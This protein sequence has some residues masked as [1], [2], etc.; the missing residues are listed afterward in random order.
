MD[1]VF[2]LAVC[3]MVS[4]WAYCNLFYQQGALPYAQG[5]LV[6]P[7][8]QWL[9]VGT[10]F[11]RN[12]GWFWGIALLIIL[13]FFGAVTITNFTTNQIYKSIFNLNPL[14]P[15]AIFAVSVPINVVF[16]VVAFFV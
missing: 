3:L 16:S 15:L 13:V 1:T 10:S 14:P 7:V 2:F 9:I 8:I 11:V 4:S 5:Y 6:F 12:F